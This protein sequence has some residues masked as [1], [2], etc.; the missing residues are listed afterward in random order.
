MKTSSCAVRSFESKADAI[1][2]CQ[3]AR[4]WEKARVLS[5]AFPQVGVWDGWRV[6]IRSTCFDKQ[7]LAGILVGMWISRNYE[8][9]DLS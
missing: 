2:A 1:R 5:P 8:G 3:L 4:K 7:F 6:A 9:I